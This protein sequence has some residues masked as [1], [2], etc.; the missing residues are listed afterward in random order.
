MQRKES[1]LKKSTYMFIFLYK[2]SFLFIE[3]L[4]FDVSYRASLF[5]GYN[6]AVENI[7]Y[8]CLSAYMYPFLLLFSP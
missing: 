1:F 3:E 4:E 8:Y 5:W 2:K 7:C 6:I